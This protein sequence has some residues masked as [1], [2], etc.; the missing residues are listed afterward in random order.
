MNT[1]VQNTIADLKR[2]VK[3]KTDEIAKHQRTIT[4]LEQTYGVPTT[5]K[6]KAKAVKR[7][8]GEGRAAK[9]KTKS[10]ANLTNDDIVAALQAVGPQNLDG[11]VE[12]LKGGG[13]LLGAVPKRLVAV[14]AAALVKKNILRKSG[15]QYVA[16][17]NA[18][19]LVKTERVAAK[20]VNPESLRA[21]DNIPTAVE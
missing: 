14:K 12:T 21:E 20:D 19:R 7:A 2:Q 8:V 11:L 18:P 13:V 5:A 1:S 16:A 4:F 17:D 6:A 10:A 9:P 3:E 15:D